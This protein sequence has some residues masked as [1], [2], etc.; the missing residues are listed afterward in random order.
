MREKE[1]DFS[2]YLTK[3][4]S[5]KEKAIFCGLQQSTI[6]LFCLETSSTKVDVLKVM[7]SLFKLADMIS[8]KSLPQP[9]RKCTLLQIHDHLKM[10]TQSIGLL[11][12]WKGGIQDCLQACG[13]DRSNGWLVYSLLQWMRNH[14]FH[15]IESVS[16]QIN[17]VGRNAFPSLAILII[18]ESTTP[19]DKAMS[20][21]PFQ[22]FIHW[23]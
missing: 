10:A 22:A 3:S 14:F 8:F 7:L 2:R 1:E 11:V 13:D 6:C 5:S 12:L 15:L 17:I 18:L 4:L 19:I 9:I 21:V 20:S 16:G 23:I